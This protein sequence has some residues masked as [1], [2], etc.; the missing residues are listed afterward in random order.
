MLLSKRTLSSKIALLALCAL[1]VFLGNIKFKQW[2]KRKQ[3]EKEKLN[4][5]T[6]ADDLQKKNRELNQSLQYLNSI[7]FKERVAREQLGL[8]KQ[9]EQVYSLAEPPRVLGAVD[10]KFKQSNWKKWLDYFF[11]IQ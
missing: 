4:L 2:Q 8:K 11:K 9:D 5:Q 10:S 7:S 1:L 3:I 6:Q